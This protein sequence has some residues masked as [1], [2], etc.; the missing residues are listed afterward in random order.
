MTWHGTG[1]LTDYRIGGGGGRAVQHTR[2]A[3][4]RLLHRA[5]ALCGVLRAFVPPGQGGTQT[6][7]LLCF[8]APGVWAG[9]DKARWG[10]GGEGVL[11]GCVDWTILYK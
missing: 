3:S 6:Q 8:E 5:E 2:V 7:V 9:L 11:P 4:C 10:K 1:L